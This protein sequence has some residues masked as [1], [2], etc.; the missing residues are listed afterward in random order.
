MIVKDE[1]DY[2]NQT[3]ASV[4]AHVDYWTIV[5]TGASQLSVD[6]KP[7]SPRNI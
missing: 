5:D 6:L 2:I 4:R 3:L 1:A 7:L